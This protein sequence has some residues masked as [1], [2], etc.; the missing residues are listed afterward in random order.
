MATASPQ[1]STF[2][3][4]VGTVMRRGSPT[5]FNVPSLPGL[6]GSATP[7]HPDF[8]SPST[9]GSLY[10][11][12]RGST[13]SYGTPVVRSA[14]RSS[15]QPREE[16]LMGPTDIWSNQGQSSAPAVIHNFPFADPK[17]LQSQPVAA[18]EQ[19]SA[20]LSPPEI[21][22]VSRA[23]DPSSPAHDMLISAR[24]QVAS[25]HR[26]VH[27]VVSMGPTDIWSNQVQSSAP[28]VVQDD[29]FTDPKCSQF[30][31]VVAPEKASADLSPASAIELMGRRA[32]N[33]AKSA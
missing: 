9:P 27:E 22:P 33:V 21:F 11:S 23:C 15:F 29:P 18:P 3:S 16:E 1:K 28:A 14:S 31:P 5:A 12:R 10:R 7:P 8:K 4:R 17:P 26:P 25:P 2:R 13:S 19:A 30:Q 32:G 20:D 24:E 6:S